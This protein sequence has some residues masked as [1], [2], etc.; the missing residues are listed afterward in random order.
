MQ[1]KASQ[2]NE[3]LAHITAA[4]VRGVVVASLRTNGRPMLPKHT[5]H[6]GHRTR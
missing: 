5:Y 2:L 3:G 6:I 4:D 1:D